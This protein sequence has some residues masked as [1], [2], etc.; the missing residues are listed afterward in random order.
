[1]KTLATIFLLAVT[2]SVHADWTVTNVMPFAVFSKGPQA[3]SVPMHE[4]D[5]A[6]KFLGEFMDREAAARKEGVVETIK[7]IG[8]WGR[9][10]RTR[11]WFEV[12]RGQTTLRIYDDGQKIATLTPADV[13]EIRGLIRRTAGS[14]TKPG[15]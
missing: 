10:P 3:L 12:L 5:A 7:Q 2:A 13:S 4:M 14:E 11:F 8:G 1:M 6:E 15:P 9:N